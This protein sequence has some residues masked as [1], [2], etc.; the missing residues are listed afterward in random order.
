MK[1]NSY[2]GFM[3]AGQDSNQVRVVAVSLQQLKQASFLQKNQ[4]LQNHFLISV[5]MR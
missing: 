3:R 4:M 1:F 5:T 2:D